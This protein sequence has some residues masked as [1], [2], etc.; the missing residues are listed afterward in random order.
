MS[1][2]KDRRIDDK[3]DN[4][5]YKETENPDRKEG[6]GRRKDENEVDWHDG[7]KRLKYK[8]ARQALSV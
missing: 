8:E 6:K 5:R 2:T 1:G 4:D 3:R 7:R